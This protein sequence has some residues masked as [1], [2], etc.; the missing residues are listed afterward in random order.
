[1]VA[2][3]YV[4]VF[5]QAQGPA[6]TIFTPFAFY[7]TKSSSGQSPGKPG[8]ETNLVSSLLVLFNFWKDSLSSVKDISDFFIFNKRK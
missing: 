2:R 4:I 8:T 1:M 3:F 6:S 7:F 5:L